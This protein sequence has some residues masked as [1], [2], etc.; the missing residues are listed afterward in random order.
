MRDKRQADRVK[1]V[2]ALSK[3]WSAAQEI[4]LKDYLVEG[5]NVV[6]IE[7]IKDG[8]GSA[9]AADRFVVQLANEDRITIVVDD[10]WKTSKQKVGGWER[11]DFDGS[12][13]L[14]SAERIK[15]TLILLQYDPPC[16]DTIRK[17]MYKTRKPR[18][19]STT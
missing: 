12:D 4:E 8:R 1:A 6:A 17:Y 7:A 3:G 5:Q 14:W 2:I 9:A 16:E 11:A 13:W 10:S 15:D 19:R 18:E